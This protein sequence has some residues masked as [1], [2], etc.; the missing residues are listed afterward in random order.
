MIEFYMT[1]CPWCERFSGKWDNLVKFFN[2]EYNQGE[3]NENNVVFMMVNGPD[4]HELGARYKVE[5]F[6]EFIYLAP[7]KKG[8]KAKSYDGER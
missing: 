3:G 5:G 7:G 4:N 8:L 6:P 1:H 2:D